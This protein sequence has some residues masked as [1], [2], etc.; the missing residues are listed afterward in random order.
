[1]LGSWDGIKLEGDEAKML[2]AIR[3]KST[4]GQAFKN[5]NIPSFSH[6]GIIPLNR[7]SGWGK[8]AVISLVFLGRKKSRMIT[9]LFRP[10]FVF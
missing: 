10:L 2:G 6:P 1:M 7:P 5:P 9:F 4:M 8:R 3:L